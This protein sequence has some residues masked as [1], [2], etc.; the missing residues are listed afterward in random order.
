M[1]ERD[2][3]EA[4]LKSTIGAQAD[5]RF[6]LRD[7]SNGFT[8]DLRQAWQAARATPQPAPVAW[9]HPDTLNMLAD[10][11]SGH[12]WARQGL[13]NQRVPLYATAQP[14]AVP[15]LTDEQI[16][17]IASDF[18]EWT[19]VGYAISDKVA[20]ARAI[21]AAAPQPSQEQPALQ[22]YQD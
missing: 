13:T 7:Y 18:S 20:F 1:S 22:K 6:M 17:E 8:N 14:V 21:L 10:G 9:I 4:W 5:L 12:V 19:E 15:A 16:M 2:E 3:F 11:K